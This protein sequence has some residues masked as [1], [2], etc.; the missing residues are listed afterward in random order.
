ML[1][2]VCRNSMDVYLGATVHY[3]YAFLRRFLL[4]PRVSICCR[5]KFVYA[6]VYLDL[7]TRACTYVH[8]YVSWCT[9]APVCPHLFLCAH[10]SWDE[11]LCDVQEGVCMASM[12]S[13]IFCYGTHEVYAMYWLLLCMGLIWLSSHRRW[14]ALVS[15]LHLADCPAFFFLWSSH[16][17]EETFTRC[18]FYAPGDELAA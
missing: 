3:S 7:S 10:L 4:I 11:H 17:R 14:A 18:G 5:C 12:C 15:S 9:H 1:I 6:L 16:G 2:E 13:R 8:V